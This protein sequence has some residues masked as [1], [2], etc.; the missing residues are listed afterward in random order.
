MVDLDPIDNNQTVEFENEMAS[1]INSSGANAES[2]EQDE[3]L[4]TKD[5]NIR[6]AL[7]FMKRL[8]DAS[9]TS[10]L[11]RHTVYSE[12]EKMKIIDKKQKNLSENSAGPDRI[13]LTSFQ[14]YKIVVFTGT[15]SVVHLVLDDFGNIEQSVPEKA[16]GRILRY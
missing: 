11:K 7:E 2:A 6:D 1:F 14:K 5:R 4:C 10:T 12:V 3:S 13:F 9:I 8:Q 16:P 15:H